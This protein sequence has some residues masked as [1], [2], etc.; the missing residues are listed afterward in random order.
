MAKVQ[1]CT[2]EWLAETGQ[3][4]ADRPE[5]KEKLKKL[6]AKMSYRIKAEPAWGIDVDI[7]F[8]AFFDQGELSKFGF[9]SE[10]D[11]RKESDYVLAAT[12]QEWKRLLRKEGKFVGDFMLGKIKLEQGSKVGVL[13]IA[14]HSGNLIDWMTQVEIQFPDEMTADELETYRSYLATFS[15]EFNV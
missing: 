9:I 4:Y 12:P 3:I 11:A 7:L 5:Y 13:S 2:P 14:P 6:S 8:A 10:A 15:K 1:Y